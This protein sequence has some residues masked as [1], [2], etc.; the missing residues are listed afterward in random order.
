M[1]VRGG[2]H[3]PTSSSVVPAQFQLPQQP[4]TQ[5][6]ASDANPAA[7]LLNPPT[8][9]NST[10][11]S[12]NA[13]APERIQLA[14]TPV[15]P[16]TPAGQEPERKL[17]LGQE[18]PK[19]T[20][21]SD[22]APAPPN[23]F[24]SA[25]PQTQLQDRP[26]TR[27]EKQPRRENTASSGIDINCDKIRDRALSDDISKINLDISPR[28]AGSSAD[29]DNAERKRQAFAEK[30]PVRQWYDHKGQFIIDGRL[31]NLTRGQ[32]VIETTAGTSKYLWD[33]LSES[34]KIY[35]AEAWQLPV[36]CSLTNVPA[37]QRNFADSDVQWRASGLCHKPLYFEEVQL[38]RYG[39]EIGPV[40][41]PVVSSAHFFA[42]IAVLPYKMGIHPAN[43]CQYALGYYRPGDCAPWTVGPVPLSLRGGIYQAA[44]VTGVAAALP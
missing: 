3:H 4:A 41:Q 43:E 33:D 44:A 9:N 31:V 29:E 2:F 15:L 26:S 10:L 32:V 28:F 12:L 30:A 35:I 11:P 36:T 5:P 34:D 7:P 25:A 6:N 1:V 19:N 17:Q 40:L 37:T 21:D 24:P 14:P 22:A 8:N 16:A 38:E 42:N 23:P 27:F 39:H 13:P 20:D 18:Q